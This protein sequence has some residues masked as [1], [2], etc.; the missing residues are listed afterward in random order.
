VY[1]GKSHLH[2]GGYFDRYKCALSFV[3]ENL[4]RINNRYKW[5]LWPNINECFSSSALPTK[6]TTSF[7]T[8]H[9]FFGDVSFCKQRAGAFTDEIM[10]S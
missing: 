5:E 8:L 4:Y 10:I 6:L 7:S 1:N 3:S 2:R 9:I